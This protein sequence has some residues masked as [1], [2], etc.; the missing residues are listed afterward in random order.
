MNPFFYSLFIFFLL[1]NIDASV[2]RQEVEHYFVSH[3]A[4]S[5]NFHGE[6]TPDNI[7]YLANTYENELKTGHEALFEMRLLEFQM[8]YSLATRGQAPIFSYDQA[9]REIGR[10][11]DKESL[12]EHNSAFELKMILKSL[13]KLGLD[14]ELGKKYHEALKKWKRAYLHAQR[15]MIDD[16]RAS[17]II[18][19]S[20]SR[21]LSALIEVASGQKVLKDLQK[22]LIIF[23]AGSSGV[24]KST[25]AENLART[26]G[27]S[28][29]FV[30]HYREVLRSL[31]PKEA[32]PALH[33]SS[34]A[35][36]LNSHFIPA[37]YEHAAA[38]TCTALDAVR[39]QIAEGKSVVWEGTTLLPNFIPPEYYDKANILY[40]VIDVDG[41]TE[42]ER[43]QNH[44]LRYIDGRAQETSDASRS[45]SRYIEKID[46]IRA[47]QKEYRDIVCKNGYNLFINRELS[48]VT[49]SILKLIKGPYVDS[50]PLDCCEV[51]SAKQRIQL[52]T[53]L[54]R[55][56]T[57]G[58]SIQFTHDQAHA[59]TL[60]ITRDLLPLNFE[61]HP[62]WKEFTQKIE[63]LG[64]PVIWKD[65]ENQNFE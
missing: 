53:E 12:L 20:H 2:L 36:P 37:F 5:V 10:L 65:R 48:V 46:Q 1:S 23:I 56:P 49:Q 51:E 26:I 52:R 33:R 44:I 8:V 58:T 19:F 60:S 21:S 61:N 42:E 6:V 35:A 11:V 57:F 63:T 39:R 15:A 47:I 25:I 40:I 27:M 50:P 22:P 62:D 14:S 41:E 43:K 17:A 32:Q 59:P 9:R 3:P 29:Q 38:V 13:E 31:I 24:G 28:A 4:F 30:D 45:P 64:E 34:F 16:P 54:K 18:D 7:T 55:C